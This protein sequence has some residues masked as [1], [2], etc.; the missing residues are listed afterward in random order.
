VRPPITKGTTIV[1]AGNGMALTA[2]STPGG[3][4]I[5]FQ[6]PAPFQENNEVGFTA[7]IKSMADMGRVLDHQKQRKKVPL[8]EIEDAGHGNIVQGYD[9][10]T[11]Y[12]TSA[13]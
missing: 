2:D 4:D 10:T 13:G 5:E 7:A 3:W 12:P 9:D 8:Q 6:T 11:P 1:D